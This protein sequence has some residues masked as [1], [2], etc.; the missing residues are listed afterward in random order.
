M[1]TG[2]EMLRAKTFTHAQPHAA[3]SISYFQNQQQRW[4]GWCEGSLASSPP[5]ALP[6][7]G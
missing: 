5:S 1:S 3:H 7:Q 6:E 4:L 2:T